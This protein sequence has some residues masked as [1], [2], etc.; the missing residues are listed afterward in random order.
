M[1]LSF[2]PTMALVPFPDVRGAI[3]ACGMLGHCW[4]VRFWRA[5]QAGAYIVSVAR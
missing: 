5:S 1:L 4:Q 2:P 3:P